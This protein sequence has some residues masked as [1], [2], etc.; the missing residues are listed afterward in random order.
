MI[1][2][3]S[4]DLRGGKVVRLKEGDPNR[5]TTFSDN[6]V[7]TAQRWIDEGAQWLHMVNLDG[8]LSEANDNQRIL[9]Q[10]TP[11]GVPVQFGGGLRSLE[12]I[13]QAFD[14]GAARVVLGTVAIQQPEI[15]EQAI[16]R[17]GSE[18]ICIGLDTRNGKV[19]THGWQNVTDTTPLEL[20]KAMA[21]MGVR[22]ALFTDVS[23]DGG[24]SGANIQT[25]IDLG[26]QTNLQIIAS[27]GVSSVPEI[28]QLQ[29]S[30]N[31]A[32]AIIGMALYTG[33]LSLKDALIAA[34][35]S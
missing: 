23:R 32:G 6:P 10:V 27:G 35:G 30:G 21:K 19:A 24:L 4:I 3:P 34:G 16:E 7:E 20:G 9:E 18:A 17:W 13:Q 31:V 26:R 1:I 8:T 33:Q 2:Y 25:T 28:E 5:Q 14:Q 12:D 15:V 29:A 22:H 11:L